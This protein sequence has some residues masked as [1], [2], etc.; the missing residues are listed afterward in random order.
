MVITKTPFRIS[1]FGGGTDYPLWYRH[2]G[3]AVL[4]ATIDKYCH[5][6]CRHLPNFFDHNFLIRYSQTETVKT[7]QDIKHPSVRACLQFLNYTRG[8]EL[9][10]TGDLP[11]RSGL[12]SS[13]TFTVGL[14][15]AL[16]ALRGEIVSK[17]KLALDAIH[18]EQNLIGEHVGSQDQTAA[19]FGGF[20]R[21][22][23]GGPADILVESIP[24]SQ[25]ALIPFE[26]SLMLFF[27][28]VSRTASV[29]A[30]DQLKRIGKKADEYRRM[31]QLVSEAHTILSCANINGRAFGT[32]LHEAWLIKKSFSPRVSSPLVDDI[33]ADARAAGAIGG[34]ILGAG[35]GGFMLF[36]VPPSRQDAVKRRLGKLLH[37]PFRFEHLG[38]H[39]INNTPSSL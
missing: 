17:K 19:A 10:H 25:S 26:K 28:G 16:Y 8:I 14:L 38:S 37:V 32:L 11:A 4:S 13:S 15:L 27:T 7:V 6:I 29:I 21:I 34:K 36:C 2:N 20:N 18:V 1:F 22:T 35:G 12:G 9:V 5:I 30:E 33:Y 39:I 23:F 31:L 24:L 3:G